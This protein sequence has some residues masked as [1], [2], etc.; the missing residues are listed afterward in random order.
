MRNIVLVTLAAA[1]VVTVAAPPTAAGP[2]QSGLKP[3]RYYSFAQNEYG[4]YTELEDINMKRGTGTH[5]WTA[6]VELVTDWA[7]YFGWSPFGLAFDVDGTMYT[8]QN[9]VAFDPSLVRS[10]LARVDSNTGAVTPI[11]E[12]V[13]FNTS[14]PDIDAQ[15]NLYVCGF[16]VDALG[17]IWGNSSLWRIDK[18]TGEFIE[19]GDTGHTNWMDLAFDSRGTLWGTF[20]NELYIIDTITGASTFMTEIHGVPNAGDPDRMEVMSIAFDKKDVLYGTAMTVY[21][22][23]PNGS[24]VLS[25]DTVTGQ[26]TG[27]GYTNQPYN[28]GG[29]I[30]FENEDDQGENAQ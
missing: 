13:P 19:V 6:G 12:P 30:L 29:D 1:V 3:D 22:E 9:I 2:P 25:I 10:Q 7:T 28:H 14:G 4:F 8:T 26:A 18:T 5:L 16:Q 20:D 15:G 17:Y 27:V 11:G 23:D 21:Y 24:P